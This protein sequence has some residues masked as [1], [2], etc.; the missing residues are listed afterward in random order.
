MPI[1]KYIILPTLLCLVCLLSCSSGEFS[2]KH[3]VSI[4]QD[5]IPLKL[6]AERT[7]LYLSR[8]EEKNIGLVVN[9]TSMIGSVHLIDTLIA[10]DCNIKKIFAPEHGFRGE[11]DAGE[12]IMDGKDA[13]TGI[14]VISLY[15]SQKKP[16]PKMLEGLDLLIFDIQDVGVRFYTYTS[17][18]TYVMEACAEQDIPFMVLD[19]PNPNGSYVDGP[20][21]E[22]DCRSFVG[23]HPVPIVHGLT[24]GE[25]ARMINGEGWLKDK[26]SCDLQVIA[27]QGYRHDMTYELPI[28]PSP[29]LPNMRSIYLYPSLCLF[30][31]T[32][33]SVGRGTQKQF[34][35][36][37][38]PQLR[39]GRVEFVPSPQKGAQHPKHEGTLC[40]GFDLS[41]ENP[42]KCL[43]KAS[44][45]LCYLL[46]L[47][48][49]LEREEK[50]DFFLSNNFFDKLA[51]N[52][53]LR[54]QVSDGLTEAQ[55]RA[56]WSEKLNAYRS[57]REKYL[58]YD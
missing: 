4:D 41:Q 30:E 1:L 43:S 18:M 15:G 50:E 19:R 23:L 45:Q 51:G 10:L 36:Y 32:Q 34:Q 58:I 52:T 57:I 48:K 13:K 26:I 5:S 38:H 37:G 35:I 53:A 17:T 46:D 42:Q 25:Y 29:N 22:S 28:P 47:Y 56:S 7:E 3:N 27:C 12:S 8:I 31:G 33:T 14:P 55:I 44:V 39:T 21:L 2:D 6:G 9:H 54:K 11:V 20:V 49:A 24:V 40:K 16:S